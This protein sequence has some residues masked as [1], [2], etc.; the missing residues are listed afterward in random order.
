MSNRCFSRLAELEDH[1]FSVGEYPDI[2]TYTANVNGCF[3]Y[4]DG[5][6]AGFPIDAA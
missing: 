2:V 1:I 3:V 4:V 6:C 5:G